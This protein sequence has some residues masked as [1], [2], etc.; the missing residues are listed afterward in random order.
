MN[1]VARRPRK[2]VVGFFVVPARRVVVVHSAH[3][4][5][6]LGCWVEPLLMKPSR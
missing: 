6:L 5:H 1:D 4:Q 2:S 3:S